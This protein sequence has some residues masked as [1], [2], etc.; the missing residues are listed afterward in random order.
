MGSRAPLQW[1]DHTGP[2][3]SEE[4]GRWG[5][6]PGQE[7]ELRTRSA[8]PAS[9][10]FCSPLWVATHSVPARP[11]QPGLSRS[12]DAAPP[13]PVHPSRPRPWSRCCYSLHF[14]RSIGAIGSRL[15]LRMGRRQ[16]PQLQEL[17]V[18]R[19]HHWCESQLCVTPTLA[20]FP[21]KST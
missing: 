5:E 13:P 14:H 4:A 3:D 17:G 16:A 21:Y 6:P 11:W 2:L 1:G 18:A 7:F 9:A 12:A 10:A 15:G 20:S 8:Q 19:P